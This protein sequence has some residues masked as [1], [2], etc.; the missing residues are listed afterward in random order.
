[1]NFF[2]RVQFFNKKRENKRI[3]VY[4]LLEALQQV[5]AAPE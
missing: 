3:Y 1:M 2:I 5:S 4:L